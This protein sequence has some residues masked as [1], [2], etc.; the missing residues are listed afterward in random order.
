MADFL[1]KLKQ[2]LDRSITTVGVKSKELIETQKVKGQIS[3]I[4]QKKRKAFEKLGEMI[5]SRYQ[6]HTR[7][8]IKTSSQIALQEMELGEWEFALFEVLKNLCEGNIKTDFFDE[9]NTDFRISASSILKK[10][11]EILPTI[12]KPQPSQWLGKVL[13]RFNLHDDKITKRIKGKLETIYAFNKKRVPSIIEDVTNRQRFNEETID[14]KCKEI[15]D[16]DEQLT[17]KERQLNTIHEIAS[18]ELET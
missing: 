15:Y 8:G 12:D 6:A 7:Y 11:K 9:T 13:T 2:G 5:Y 14:T 17:E 16:L 1:E 18:K 10:V 4:E 3:S